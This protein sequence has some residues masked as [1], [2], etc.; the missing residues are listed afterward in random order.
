MPGTVPP[1]CRV[2]E[3]IQ[4]RRCSALE[5]LCWGWRASADDG[6]TATGW[7]TAARHPAPLPPA[8][9]AAQAPTEPELPGTDQLRAFT[10]Q[11]FGPRKIARITGCSERP[12]RQLLN[13]AGLRQPPPRP[14]SIDPHWLREQYQARQRSLK[15]IAAETGI[16]VESLAATARNARIPVR[17]GMNGHAHPSPASAHPA[18]SRQPSGTPSPART[19]NSASAGSSPSL[20]SQISTAQPVSSASGTPPWPA[21]SASS[22][23]SQGPRCCAPARTG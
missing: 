10:E 21:R 5:E 16:P 13:G 23:P 9:L 4:P 22:K 18:P 12:I 2:A 11:G 17:H 20:G 8:G 19:P 7:L 14:R 3:D 1:Q 15:D 6:G